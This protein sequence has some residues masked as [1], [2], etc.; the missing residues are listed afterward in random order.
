MIGRRKI[1]KTN[2]KKYSKEF[3]YFVK[4]IFNKI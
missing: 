1:N 4:E 3:K 2:I